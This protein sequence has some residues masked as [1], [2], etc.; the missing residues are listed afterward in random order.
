MLTILATTCRGLT[1]SL[2]VRLGRSLLN[3]L[4]GLGAVYLMNAV[5]AWM[6]PAEGLAPLAALTGLDVVEHEATLRRF[7]LGILL[8]GA[9]T[10]GTTIAVISLLIR[11][12]LAVAHEF[13]G[14]GQAP[15]GEAPTHV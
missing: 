9:G 11:S 10:T 4:T 8:E 3:G 2:D 1:R 5:M 14:S 13:R 12:A 6:T 7:V 15:N